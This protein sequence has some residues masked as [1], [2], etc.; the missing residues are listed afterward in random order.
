MHLKKLCCSYEYL[1][2][3]G[4]IDSRSAL[5]HIQDRGCFFP[6]D[7]VIF[8]T[9]TFNTLGAWVHIAQSCLE[10]KQDEASPF[11]KKQMPKK[12][13]MIG[14]IQ[15][16]E[17]EVNS[18]N[19]KWTQLEAITQW[20]EEKELESVGYSMWYTKQRKHQELGLT[21]YRFYTVCG[22]YFLQSEKAKLENNSS[23]LTSCLVWMSKN[24]KQNDAE[25]GRPTQKSL[26]I[27]SSKNTLECSVTKN[28]P[29]L[30]IW[31]SEYG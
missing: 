14:T 10:L 18:I 23:G 15:R 13:Q 17:S 2:A 28:R 27:N 20:D 25:N 3:A 30:N 26:W 16:A 24:V 5:R 12:K 9:Q 7:A 11:P 22:G 29:Q 19:Q 1:I 4:R 8:G 21:L 6:S 31:A